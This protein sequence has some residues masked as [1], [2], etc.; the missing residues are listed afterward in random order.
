[1][2]IL[3]PDANGSP[4]DWTN[5]GTARNDYDYINDAVTSPTAPTGYTDAVRASNSTAEE[6]TWE[7]SSAASDSSKESTNFRVYWYMEVPVGSINMRW[8]LKLGGSR[9]SYSSWTSTSSNTWKYVDF[10]YTWSQTNG[11]AGAEVRAEHA[12]VGFGAYVDLDCVYV[13]VS[14]Q[15]TASGNP[16]YYYA[17]Q[18]TI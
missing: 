3:R 16:W 17:Q 2:P 15:G 6:C 18:G 1:M 13:D 8:Q 12:G 7:L 11:F 9:T 14:T 5:Y 4:Q 10:T